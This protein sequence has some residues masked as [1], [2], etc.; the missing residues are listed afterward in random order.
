VFMGTPHRGS[1][2]VPWALLLTNV[3]NAASLGQAVRKKLLKNLE[4]DSATLN[5]ISRQFV[6]RST[7]LKIRSFIEQKIE[8]PLTT[9]VF[10]TTSLL[11][12]P[13]LTLWTDRPRTLC[14][15]QPAQRGYRPAE[16]GSSQSVP[17]FQPKKSGLRSRGMG[18]QGYCLEHS[19]CN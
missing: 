6:H 2:I 18:N 17:L 13:E 11:P 15:A 19:R 9:L 8:R 5:E 14:G 3:I 10:G 4:S 1:D 16:R 7:P 12:P